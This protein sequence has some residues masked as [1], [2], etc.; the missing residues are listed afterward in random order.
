MH[1]LPND[2]FQ[3]RWTTTL[4][5]DNAGLYNFRSVT[6]DGVRLYIDNELIIDYW[7]DPSR[8]QVDMVA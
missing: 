3:V 1:A 7:V 2:N 8:L 6:D 4:D 5:I